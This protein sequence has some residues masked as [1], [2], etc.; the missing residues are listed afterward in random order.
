[1]T[2][3]TITTDIAAPPDTVWNCWNTPEHVMQWNF[4]LDSW[5]C[6]ASTIDLRPGGEFHTTMAAKDGSM[7]FDFWGTYDVV[8]APNLL[9]ITMGDGR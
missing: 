6:P 9:N 3:I 5:H 1:M 4:A 8:E 7:S 2:P